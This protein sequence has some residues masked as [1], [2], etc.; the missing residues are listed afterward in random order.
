MQE[1]QEAE[2]AQF[3]AKNLRRFTKKARN[4][5]NF[6]KRFTSIYLQHVAEAEGN[7]NNSEDDLSDGF[8][9]FLVDIK[10]EVKE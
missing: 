9:T 4:S 10:E 5:Y 6:E 1:E 2:K 8:I 3:R 7:N